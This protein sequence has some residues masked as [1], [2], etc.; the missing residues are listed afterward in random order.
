MSTAVNSDRSLRYVRE[1]AP[2]LGSTH[3]RF[4]RYTR[5]YLGREKFE[6]HQYETYVELKILKLLRNYL[7][8]IKKL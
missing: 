3:C 4:S 1:Y 2:A 8:K 7:D 5:Y 6:T